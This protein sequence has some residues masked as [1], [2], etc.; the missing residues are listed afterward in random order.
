MPREI[1]D[2][3]S[4]IEGDKNIFVE[5]QIHE[6]I[7][8]LSVDYAGIV[9]KALFDPQAAENLRR[10]VRDIVREKMPNNQ[11]KAAY[12]IMSTLVGFGKLQQLI[13][14]PDVSEIMVN[15]YNE[16]WVERKG[17]IEKTNISFDSPKEL[18]TF[19]KIKL[20]G[21]KQKSLN[22]SS[23]ITMVTFPGGIRVRIVIPPVSTK[24]A[25]INIRKPVTKGGIIGPKELLRSGMLTKE[26]LTF[27]A[28]CVRGKLNILMCGATGTGKTTIARVLAKMIPPSER[29]IIAEVA[30]ELSL[31]NPHV[32]SLQSVEREDNP[33]EIKD[34]F[35]ATLQMRPDRFMI[36]ETTGEE[37]FELVEAMSAAYRGG[38]TTLH[39]DSPED[40][41]RRLTIMIMRN[42]HA[43]M[44]E[45]M[46]Q[47][48]LY[49]TL[50]ILV[51]VRRF[52]TGERKIVG[53]VEVVPNPPGFRWIF[54]YKFKTIEN[55]RLIGE[56][57]F[58]NKVSNRLRNL[59]L[60]HN[61][62]NILKFSEPLET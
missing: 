61:W 9:S 6:I 31:T 58:E 42:P 43:K 55:N 4:Y 10:I 57:V 32:V 26:M 39:A 29:I 51:F 2:L 41:I 60:E 5:D 48:M 19:A 20:A 21:V 18:D 15:D 28:C 34:V 59:V 56:H 36:G 53:I 54:R 46:I 25:I 47:E 17:K 22:Q 13:D 30:P 24:N 44:S 14:D 11:D 62:L 49:E 45:K 16:I 38:I 35:R 50:H 3:R 7:K 1:V 40:A 23:P 27:L 8:N 33:I 52:K 12:Q 37:A